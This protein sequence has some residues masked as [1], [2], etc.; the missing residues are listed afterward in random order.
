MANAEKL[1]PHILKW[2][3]GV[4]KKSTETFEQYFNRCRSKGWTNDPLDMGGATQSGLT[5][6]A[7]KTYCKKHGISTPTVD[8]LKKIPYSTWLAIF[9]ED[10][11][12]RWQADKIVSQS[13]ANVLV[14]YVW[15]SGCYGIT[16]IQEALGLKVDGIVGSK[17]LA[18]VNGK[19][20]L[21]MFSLAKQVRE[22]HYRAIVKAKPSQAKW[23][24]GWL[25]RLNDL[26]WVG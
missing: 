3:T 18:M 2:E 26:Q 25:N 21:Q 5:L 14:D 11:W 20:A 7:Y 9:K 16:K 15:G 23:L 19:S 24:K 10:Y 22:K 8:N 12:D 4:V 17:T 6:N 13:V 1:I